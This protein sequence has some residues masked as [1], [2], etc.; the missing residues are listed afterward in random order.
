MKL[1]RCDLETGRISL[2]T[3]KFG[4]NTDVKYPA[5]FDLPEDRVIVNLLSVAKELGINLLDTAPAYGNSEHR[6]GQLLPGLRE[7]W[8]L[9]TKAGEQYV[10]GQSNY[11][12]S[13]QAV[14]DSVA[15]SYTHLT[16]PT[17]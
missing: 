8:I 9:C 12:F 14:T 10:G 6:I 15:V 5:K 1:G 7:D 4:R 11:D 16:L 2:G 13:K 17:N 3:V